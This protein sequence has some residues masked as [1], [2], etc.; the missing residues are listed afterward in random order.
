MRLLAVARGRGPALAV[1]IRDAHGESPRLLGPPR[2][3]THQYG[4]GEV[5]RFAALDYRPGSAPVRVD[6]QGAGGGWQVVA[7]PEYRLTL[8]LD[9]LRGSVRAPR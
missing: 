2:T 9:L 1:T 4:G 6:V 8:G 7:L 3:G 5:F